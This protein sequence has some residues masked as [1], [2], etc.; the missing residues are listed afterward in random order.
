MSKEV[1]NVVM[2]DELGAELIVFLREKKKIQFDLDEDDLSDVA[3][4]REIGEGFLEFLGA[5]LA[6]IKSKEGESTIEVP[7]LITLKTSFREGGKDGNWGVGAEVGEEIKK[8]IKL[9][10]SDDDDDS[11]DEDE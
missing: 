6:E 5:K 10:D 1:K 3:A 7:G 11:E 4:A 8:S 9:L 2:D